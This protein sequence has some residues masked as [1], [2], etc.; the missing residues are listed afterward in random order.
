MCV[1]VRVWLLVWVVGMMRVGHGLSTSAHVE[2]FKSA[3]QTDSTC[4]VLC[5][6]VSESSR[7]KHPVLPPPHTHTQ[8]LSK[9]STTDLSQLLE[10]HVLPAMRP[11]PTGWKDGESVK[12]LLQGRDIKAKLGER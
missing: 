4:K 8:T 9:A 2:N 3:P 7:L 12:T 10:Y 11:V 5:Q 1:C 6:Q